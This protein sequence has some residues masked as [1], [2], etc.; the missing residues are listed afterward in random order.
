M[1]IN[2]EWPALWAIEAPVESDIPPLERIARPRIMHVE[3]H[4]D[5][6]YGP[7]P[8]AREW[9]ATLYRNV[10]DISCTAPDTN[11][12][13]SRYHAFFG[14]RALGL[15]PAVSIGSATLGT[16]DNLVCVTIRVQ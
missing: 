5:L 11:G 16:I 4:V 1:S 12:A 2:D 8:D 7:V 6:S 9:R 15:D 10:A 13:R 14:P 3:D